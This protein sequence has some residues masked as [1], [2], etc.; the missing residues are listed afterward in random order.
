VPAPIP[1]FEFATPIG[2]T[3]PFWYDPSYWFEGLKP[4]VDV[5]GR[6][7]IVLDNIVMYVTDFS[8]GGTL[9]VG[10]LL[11]SLMRP[12]A[13]LDVKSIW[14]F[15]G[16]LAPAAAA[17]AMF[18]MVW[19][20]PRMLGPWLVLFYMGAYGTRLL[21]VSV[22][23]RRVMGSIVAIVVVAALIPVGVTSAR[24]AVSIVR[25][26][27]AGTDVNRNWQI[28][29]TLQRM[30]LREG[31][32]VAIL[33]VQSMS[34]LTH[35]LWAHLARVRIVA[36]GDAKETAGHVDE[37]GVF[38]ALE[39]IGIKLVVADAVPAWSLPDSWQPIADSGYFAHFLERKP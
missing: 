32:R 29:Q 24:A 36:E 14:A 2:G 5:E 13:P 38:K 28:A 34:G 20:V 25:E 33:R 31:D 16:V 7:R 12:S 17:L 26:V 18:T 4:A 11:L 1:I 37:Q 23:S 9:V 27:S 19:L 6:S 39:S 22:D 10:L 8:L 35:S 3:Y 30:G 15:R 21:P